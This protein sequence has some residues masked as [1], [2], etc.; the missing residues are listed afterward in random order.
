MRLFRRPTL[1]AGLGWIA[2]AL[3]ATAAGL[4]GIRL[5]GDSLTGT[6]GGV[7]SQ[8]EVQRALAVAQTSPAAEEP[9]GGPSS[10]AAS[11]ADPAPRPATSPPPLAPSST[12]AVP[13]SAG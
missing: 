11:S 8:D 6:P 3:V 9:G 13:P 10:P 1:A 4:G 7:L 12:T 2:A 5:V